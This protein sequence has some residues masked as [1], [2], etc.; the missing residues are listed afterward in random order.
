MRRDEL[1]EM[2]SL[3]ALGMLEADEAA[4]F[5]RS[6]LEAP[7]VVQE[8]IR[9]LQA[10]VVSDAQL[11]S[12]EE[13]PASLRSRVI[14]SVLSAVDQ[15]NQGLAPIATI[16]SLKKARPSAS[17]T[18]ALLNE[19]VRTMDQLDEVERRLQVERQS[20]RTR[21]M[22]RSLMAWRAAT[23]GCAASLLATFVW[24]SV[25][26]NQALKV[27]Q[28]AQNTS[29]QQEIEKQ[30]GSSLTQF[31]SSACKVRSL[32][33]TNAESNVAGVLYIDRKSGESFLVAF[34]LQANADYTLRLKSI[35]GSSTDLGRL[36]GGGKIA[37]AKFA[38]AD[39]TKLQ[40]EE[41]EVLDAKGTVVLSTRAI[42]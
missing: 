6:F 24:V 40:F 8:E 12:D 23:V 25:I 5:S 39:V 35:D 30:L 22:N 28:L 9:A 37:G 41:I 20:I 38:S 14:G 29:T 3:D 34:G 16:G 17:T 19:D 42:L 4:F 31:Y 11:L 15:E 27:T 33:T 32:V 21:S 36:T 7:R 13:P 2:A 1:L 26:A 10:S 18:T